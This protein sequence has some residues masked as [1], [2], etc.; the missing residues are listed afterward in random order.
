MQRKPIVVVGS[1]NTD[2]V[3]VSE[4]IPSIGQ[5]VLGTDFQVHPGERAAT[6]LSPW[7]ASATLST[8]SAAL[9]A[10]TLAPSYANTSNLAALT[11]ARWQLARA[12]PEWR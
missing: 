4:R 11:A 9:A 1:V 3:A 12:R 2:L 8:S 7:R 5:T 10:T 6:R